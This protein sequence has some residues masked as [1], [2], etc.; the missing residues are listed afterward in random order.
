MKNKLLTLTALPAIVF[1]VSVGCSSTPQQEP[2]PGEAR[3]P[4]AG[5]GIALEINNDLPTTVDCTIE[6]PGRPN[7]ILG[8][9]FSNSRQ[10]FIIDTSKIVAGFRVLCVRQAGQS[11]RSD[12]IQTISK[13]KITYTLS[14]G[15]V[16]V[17]SLP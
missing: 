8:T 7:P 3:M 16:R 4:T 17:E 13:A 9:V 10:T 2:T 11:V 15:L 1:A 5:A 6:A 12:P 14:T